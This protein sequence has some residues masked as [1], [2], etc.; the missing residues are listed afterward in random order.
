[1]ITRIVERDG[2]KH[3]VIGLGEFD[4]A[5]LRRGDRL[6]ADN[7]LAPVRI[8]FDDGSLIERLNAALVGPRP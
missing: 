3:V 7:E 2:V 1:M 8:A 6:D 4:F 5:R